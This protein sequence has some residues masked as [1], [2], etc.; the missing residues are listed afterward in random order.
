MFVQ[1]HIDRHLIE[2][3]GT[4]NSN[5]NTYSHTMPCD[6]TT[7]M[8][9]AENGELHKCY[10]FL[11]RLQIA[12]NQP[13]KE[14]CTLHTISEHTAISGCH[15]RG[16]SSFRKTPSGCGHLRAHFIRNTRGRTM[17]AA[18]PLSVCVCV[19]LPPRLQRSAIVRR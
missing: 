16:H 7:G 1:L 13:Q 12:A 19:L 8:H 17:A 4:Q 18:R 10:R 6:A 14:M 15:H 11:D 9:C 3:T 5:A 2:M